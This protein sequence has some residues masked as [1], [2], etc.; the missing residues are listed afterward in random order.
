MDE[1]LATYLSHRLMD[2]KHGKNSNLLA[3]PKGL[4]WLPNIQR[5]TYRNY[6]ML[7]TIGRGEAGPTVQEMPRY[8]HLANLLS[9]CYDRG[10]RIVGMIENHL[11]ESAFLD[12]MQIIYARYSF[13]ILRVADFQHELESYT[14]RSWE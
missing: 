5:E 1:G 7:G 2:Q 3:F 11:G 4:E 14:G 8:K 12:F 13:R 10:G 9:M 6:T